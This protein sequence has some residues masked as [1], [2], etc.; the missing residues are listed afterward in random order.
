[1]G[2]E[3]R[4]DPSRKYYTRSRKRFGRVEREY[5]GCGPSAALEANQDNL[6]RPGIKVSIKTTESITAAM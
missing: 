3:S 4:G 5:V 6:C 1:M 2:W